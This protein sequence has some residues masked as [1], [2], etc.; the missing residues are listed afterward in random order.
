MTIQITQLENQQ[1]S[2]FDIT[3]SDTFTLF[4]IKSNTCPTK[5]STIKNI[6]NLGGY[7]EFN[8]YDITDTPFLIKLSFG[9]TNFTTEDILQLLNHQPIEVSNDQNVNTRIYYLPLVNRKDNRKGKF[10]IDTY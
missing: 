4:K 5:T 3:T 2:L 1:I 7:L 9:K 6:K 8:L 10:I